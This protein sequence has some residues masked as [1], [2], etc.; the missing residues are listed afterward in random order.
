MYV[1]VPCSQRDPLVGQVAHLTRSAVYLPVHD[2]A[3]TIDFYRRALDFEPE[4]VAGQ[5]A[6]FAIVSR[7]GF[8]ITLRRVSED[9][10]LQQHR[11]S[12]GAWD[13]FFWTNN[14]RSLCEE[15]A[16]KAIP[17]RCDSSE[18][19]TRRAHGRWKS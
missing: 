14:A 4:Y 7:S 12:E 8:P 11:G 10:P 15:Y 5:P 17:I 6:E 1:R 9:T 2:P 13:V 18:S 16:K 3:A 19:L